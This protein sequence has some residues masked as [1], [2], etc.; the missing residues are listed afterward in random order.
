MALS[1]TSVRFA[2]PED[3][4]RAA[5]I[6]AGV[7]FSPCPGTGTPPEPTRAI[8]EGPGQRVQGRESGEPDTAGQ[9]PTRE[10][11]FGSEPNAAEVTTLV[12]GQP[13]VGVARVTATDAG[14]VLESL[15][16]LP[17]ARGVGTGT[18]LLQAV[19]GLVL[20]AG[21]DALLAHTHTEGQRTWLERHGFTEQQDR[22]TSPSGTAGSSQT[23][24]TM[25]RAIADEPEPVP[26][27]SVLPVRD[28]PQGLEVFVQHRVGTMDFV[29]N[30]VVFPGGR[31][32][33]G[34]D[35]AGA[36]LDLPRSLLDQH[37]EAW[38]EVDQHRFGPDEAGARTTVATGLREVAEEA[39]VR[40]DPATLI[41]WDNWITPVGG[42]R[43]FDVRYFVLPV[44]DPGT[45]ER[46]RNTTT[47]AHRSEWTP[48]A[49]LEAAAENRDLLL[50]VPTRVLVEELATF[51]SVAEIVRHR[52]R[53]TPVRHDMCA[54]PG[55]RPGR[56]RATTG[57]N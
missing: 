26:A 54:T 51:A 14:H 38:A 39:G 17:E 22:P 31:V 50:V 30:A 55:R 1:V 24:V 29:P 40:A 44:T 36:A 27:V 8:G 47:E 18:S 28:G 15:V 6:A 13:A 45:A 52:P 48:V 37:T 11:I 46:F 53:I 23:S 57:E 4:P 42:P 41:P 35:E 43:R 2:E 12:I 19:F 10:P 25:V 21:G 9:A 32:D 56:D 33:P 7:S 5:S 3:L 49:E 16:V 20:D 34:D